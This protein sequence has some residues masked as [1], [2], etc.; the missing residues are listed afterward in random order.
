MSLGT[1]DGTPCKTVKAKLMHELEK[2]VEHSGPVGSAL[3]VDGVALIHQIHTMTSTFGQLADR[4]LQDLM[5]MEIQCRCLRV[6]FVCDQYPV[7][8]IKNCERDAMGGTQVIHIPRP[9]QKT[10]KQFKKYL[11][12]RRNK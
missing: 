5:H 7:Q 8:S 10:P 3:I 2:G 11:A 12:N 4:L 1:T 6:D 9:D